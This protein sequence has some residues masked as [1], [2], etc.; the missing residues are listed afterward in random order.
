MNVILLGPPGAGKGTQAQRLQERRGLVQL[1]TG[2]MLRAAVAS[3][4]DWAARS[5]RSWTRRP[6]CPTT[7]SRYDFRTDRPADAGASS[8]MV[9]PHH[10][11]GPGARPDGQGAGSGCS[12]SV[13]ELRVDDA[14]LI[15][16]ITGRSPAPNAVRSITTSSSGRSGPGCATSAAAPNSSGVGRQ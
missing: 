2:D 7:S 15:D 14:A 13:I 4:S 3:G 12:T 11:P 6:W 16:R 9:S 8:W 10:P 5:V 1:S